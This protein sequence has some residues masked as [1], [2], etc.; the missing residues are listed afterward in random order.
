MN[1]KNYIDST[2]LKTPQQANIT[3][4]QNNIIVAQTIEEAIQEKYYLV[5][6]RSNYVAFAKKR[7]HDSNA[8]LAIGTVISFPEGT[9]TTEQKLEEATLAINNGAD[10]LDF[11]CN[12]TAFLNG[13]I[14]L[15]KNEIIACTQLVL[16]HQKIIKWIIEVA[17]LTNT[18]IIKLTSLIKNTIIANFKETQFSNIFIKSSTGFFV[19]PH[20]TT[21]GATIETITL[22]LENGFPLPIKAAGGIKNHE[23]AMQYINLGVKRIGT[24]S[25]KSICNNT[26]SITDY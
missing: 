14:P 3:P 11:V 20:K 9:N 8:K 12:Y 26:E 18:E 10:E 6:L 5:M 1:L 4:E 2:Y 21:N 13:D 23:E 16:N 15:I 25:A 24:S 19:T 22:M 7:I 17:A